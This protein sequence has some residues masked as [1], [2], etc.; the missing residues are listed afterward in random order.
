MSTYSIKV[1]LGV[2]WLRF[3]NKTTILFIRDVTPKTLICRVLSLLRALNRHTTCWFVSLMSP[4]PTGSMS[5]WLF[6]YVERSRMIDSKDC[7]AVFAR[8]SPFVTHHE[9]NTM[10]VWKM[11][12]SYHKFRKLW[13]AWKRYC[14]NVKCARFVVVNGLKHAKTHLRP[15][16]KPQLAHG[17]YGGHVSGAFHRHISSLNHFTSIP[18]DTF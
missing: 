15:L 17:V 16:N 12:K 13:Y 4:S 3:I 11:R 10:A 18:R 6:G 14:T 8:F 5:D 9:L 1:G 2:K 7:E